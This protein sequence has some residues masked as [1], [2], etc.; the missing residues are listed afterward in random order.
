MT[1]DEYTEVPKPRFWRSKETSEVK[2]VGEASFEIDD[3]EEEELHELDDVR[4][5]R[6]QTAGGD[7]MNV[8]DKIAGHQKFFEN[9]KQYLPAEMKT[10]FE[11]R[12]DELLEDS[13]KVH[14][15]AGKRA[16][17]KKKDT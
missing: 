15:S 8:Q 5:E 14:E 9:A 3:E 4:N 1:I 2:L 11:Q 12:I 17:K 10:E 6:D 7:E 16:S 13:K